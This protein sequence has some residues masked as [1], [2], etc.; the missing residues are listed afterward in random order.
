MTKPTPQQRTKWLSDAKKWDQGAAR[1]RQ[2]GREQAARDAETTAKTL[3]A[4]AN[5]K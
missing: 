2:T 4:A 3:R 1:F 5:Q